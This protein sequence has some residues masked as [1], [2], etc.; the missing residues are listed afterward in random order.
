MDQINVIN[1]VL[2]NDFPQEINEESISSTVH[3]THAVICLLRLDAAKQSIT[4]HQVS[5][6]H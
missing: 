5:H 6:M 1:R 2:Q 4:E 3:S